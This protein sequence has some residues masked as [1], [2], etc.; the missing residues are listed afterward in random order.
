MT[1]KI[2]QVLE[3]LLVLFCALLSIIKGFEFVLNAIITG[4][5]N[6]ED[7]LSNRVIRILAVIPLFVVEIVLLLV[8]LIF[9][10]L[11]LIAS[12]FEKKPAVSRSS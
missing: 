7:I 11:I 3:W 1:G 6:K 2:S 12:N 10:L 8:N 5:L 4:S 9:L